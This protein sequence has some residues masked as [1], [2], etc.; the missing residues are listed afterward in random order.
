M[1]TIALKLP[2]GPLKTDRHGEEDMDFYQFDCALA[3]NGVCEAIT[4]NF[5]C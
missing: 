2:D 1:P 4:S 3:A 5:G